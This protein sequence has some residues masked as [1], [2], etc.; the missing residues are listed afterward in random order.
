MCCIVKIFFK[1][2]VMPIKHLLS[3]SALTLL[4]LS[5]SAQYYLPEN[6]TWIMANKT[7]LDF[8]GLVPNVITSNLTSANEGVASVSD[9]LGNLLFYTNGTNIWGSNHVLM[10]NG[11]NINGSGAQTASTTQGALIVPH[12]IDSNLYYVFSQTAVSNCRLFTNIVDKSLNNGLG[13]IVTTYPLKGIALK[14]GLTEKMV[15]VPACDNTVWVIVRSQSQNAFLSYKIN[16]Y[17]LDTTPV[18]SAVGSFTG[19]Y[20]AQ[21]VMKSSAD[22]SKLLTCNFK[23]NNAAYGVEVFDFDG[24]TGMVSNPRL[25]DTICVYGGA[26]SP[27]GN[28][29]YVQEVSVPGNVYQYDLNEENP[30]NVKTFL[31][32]SGQ[33]ADMKLAPDGA[34]YFAS[35]VQ[36]PGF[37]S[38]RYMGKIHYPNLS[39][40]NCG[41]QDTV[42]TMPFLNTAQTAGTLAQGLPNEVVKPFNIAQ[43]Q[44]QVALDT[45]ICDTTNFSGLM[46][47]PSLQGANF[48]WNDATTASSKIITQTGVYWVSYQSNCRTI[49]D[50]FYINGSVM[51]N[52]DI[53]YINGMLIASNGFSNYQWYKNDTLLINDTVIQLQPNESGIYKV[54]AQS[55]NGCAKEATYT[56]NLNTN[57]DNLGTNKLN[58]TIYP[59]PASNTVQIKNTAAQLTYSINI[60]DIIGTLVYNSQGIHND[61]TL[62]IKDWNN[63]LYIIIITDEFGKQY[64]MKFTKS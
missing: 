55:N 17:G 33:Y 27:N 39:G 43:S 2:S 5:S 41:F 54:I 62:N 26:F 25:L 28:K 50:T 32:N 48:M 36:S 59:N 58:F 63:G 47:S 34:I 53:D 7:G 44:S 30:N 46:L 6:K 10:P 12:P 64:Y 61:A 51:P 45:F 19:D 1:Q 9:G 57:I 24:S 35:A 60:Y 40:V 42:S 16:E 38:Y 14:D 13:D 8:N 29:V 23:G 52:L 49:I 20:Y 11:S 37:N 3:V 4:S 31:G 18:V 15:A 22:G 56:L 21:G